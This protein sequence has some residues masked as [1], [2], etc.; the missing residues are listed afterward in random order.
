MLA[1]ATDSCCVDECEGTWTMEEICDSSPRSFA[2]I[3]RSFSSLA[4]R[5]D[6]SLS[7]PTI[8]SGFRAR[9]RGRR[10]RST[11]IHTRPS[12]WQLVQ[13]LNLSHFTLRWRH[14]SQVRRTRGAEDREWVVPTWP[15]GSAIIHRN[16]I[17]VAGNEVNGLEMDCSIFSMYIHA[18]RRSK[19]LAC[20]VLRHPREAIDPY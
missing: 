5:S 20:E 6:S 12:R 4:T 16:T 2:T 10:A 13:G 14:A 15:T 7:E 19:A 9:P 8:R 18:C 1:S 17:C 3:F 11:G